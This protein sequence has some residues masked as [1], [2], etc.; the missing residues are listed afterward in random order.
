MHTNGNTAPLNLARSDA[1]HKRPWFTSVQ[2]SLNWRK[3]WALIGSTDQTLCVLIGSMLSV[4][5]CPDVGALSQLVTS[6]L[7]PNTGVTLPPLE[8]AAEPTEEGSDGV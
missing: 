8:G 4:F 2:L 6:T 7:D 3:L 1:T 5:M